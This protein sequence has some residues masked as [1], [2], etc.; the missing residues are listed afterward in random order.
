MTGYNGLFRP[1]ENI[2]RA[3]V[4]TI[5]NHILGRAADEEYV[6]ANADKLRQFPDLQD[7]RAWYYFD[8]VEAS[9][10]HDFTRDADGTERWT[11]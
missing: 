3:E 10:E 7:S 9:N 5:V 1:T 8:M 11:N 4:A 2:T 6:K